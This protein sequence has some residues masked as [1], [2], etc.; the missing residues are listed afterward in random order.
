MMCFYKQDIGAHS[1]SD[2][3]CSAVCAPTLRAA[4]NQNPDSEACSSE[5]FI[6]S[7]VKIEKGEHL[8]STLEILSSPLAELPSSGRTTDERL[9]RPVNGNVIPNQRIAAGA[10][11][12]SKDALDKSVG[13]QKCLTVVIPGKVSIRYIPGP[14]PASA[15]DHDVPWTA[16]RMRLMTWKSQAWRTARRHSYSRTNV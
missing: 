12:Q 8:P 11:Q 6:L 16:S 4:N 1:E 3:R 5:S 7:V 13:I 2:Q 10:A 9:G 14:S 15:T